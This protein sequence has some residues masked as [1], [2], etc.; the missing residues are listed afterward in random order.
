MGGYSDF[1]LTE[2]LPEI[3][4][5]SEALVGST[6]QNQVQLGISRRFGQRTSL[7]ANL[8]RNH[9]TVDFSGA[10]IQQTYDN[11]AASLTVNPAKGLMVVVGGAYTDNLAGSL[12]EPTVEEN[13]AILPPIS[14]SSHSIDLSASYDLH[15]FPRPELPGQP[16]EHRAQSLFRPECL[17]R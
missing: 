6:D 4:N 12:L 2:T 9:F 15:S 14:A 10:P 11:A 8:S 7:I 16:V 1:K 13:G 3:T 5:G 17:L